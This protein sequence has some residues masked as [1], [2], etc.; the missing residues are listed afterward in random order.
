[1]AL[2]LTTITEL[3]RYIVQDF[4]RTAS[5]IFTYENSSIFTLSE[6]NIVS[7][8]DVG[9][10]DVTSGTT[11]SYSSATNQV[12]VSGASA[13]DTVEVFYSYYSNY[14]DTEIEGYIRAALGYISINRYADYQVLNS[15]VYPTP[16]EAD[17]NLIAM[18]ASILIEPDNKTYRLPDM[19]ISVPFRSLLTPDRI[20][21]TIS[22][23]KRDCHGIF[24]IL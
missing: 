21:K 20:A 18:V 3:V 24:E 14:T 4:A 22:I 10:N 2:T 5:D 19:S 16:P 17:K 11:Y 12:T 8:S 7:V 15:S 23:F 9:I 13:G 1:M 6:P